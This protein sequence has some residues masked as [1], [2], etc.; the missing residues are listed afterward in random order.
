MPVKKQVSE[1]EKEIEEIE[2]TLQYLND[3]LKEKLRFLKD[4]V[5]NY[6]KLDEKDKIVVEKVKSQVY[7]IKQAITKTRKKIQNLQYKIKIK[8][9]SLE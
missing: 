4:N 6:D 7:D 2:R 5:R 9:V 8:S 1:Y 3:D